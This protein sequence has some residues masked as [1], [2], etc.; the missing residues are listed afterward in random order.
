MFMWFID[1]FDKIGKY[2][3]CYYLPIKV[4]LTVW[5]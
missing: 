5:T 3:K 4:D 2:E 1:H